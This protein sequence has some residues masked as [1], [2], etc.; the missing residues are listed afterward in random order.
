M[1]ACLFAQSI[2][3]AVREPP[4]TLFPLPG[5]EGVRGRVEFSTAAPFWMNLSRLGVLAL[6]LPQR[7]RG[8][9]GVGWADKNV[10]P[11]NLYCL[12]SSS[13]TLLRMTESS[14]GGSEDPPLRGWGAGLDESSP[15]TTFLL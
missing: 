3:G 10:R 1:S 6:T 5:R 15:Y 14:G 2:V 7:G 8:G 9:E 11:P 13:L 4:Y 12:D